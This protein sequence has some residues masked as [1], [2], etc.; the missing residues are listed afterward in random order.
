M[1][2]ILKNKKGF[3]LIE[4]IVVLVIIAILAAATVPAMIGYVNEARGK[5]FASEARVGLIAAQAVVTEQ[6]A[7]G[8]TVSTTGAITRA[9][10]STTTV[11]ATQSFQN[12]TI[13]VTGQSAAFTDI[14]VNTNNRVTGIVFKGG[15]YTVTIGNGTTDV[16][17]DE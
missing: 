6:V 7:A 5:A 2:K 3:T 1:K 9:D 16:I 15:G 17:K 12:M 8:A 10:G 4:I 13:D 14:T 11:F